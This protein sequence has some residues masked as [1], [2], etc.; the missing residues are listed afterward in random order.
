MVVYARR[1]FYK[2]FYERCWLI[3]LN[4]MSKAREA[5]DEPSFTEGG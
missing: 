3:G 1:W 5:V 2:L 4:P